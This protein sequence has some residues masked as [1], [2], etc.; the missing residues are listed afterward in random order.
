MKNEVESLIRLGKQELEKQAE[1]DPFL[2]QRLLARLQSRSR[3]QVPAARNLAWAA[4]YG[5]A[6]ALLAFI[7]LQWLPSPAFNPS[8]G[9]SVV[10]FIPFPEELQ[11]TIYQSFIE[12]ANWEK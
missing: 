11:N 4:V 7:H 3:R 8:S 2:P 1:A 5:L 9:S 10:K 6:V 12:V